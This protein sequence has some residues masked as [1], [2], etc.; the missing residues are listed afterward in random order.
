MAV[1]LPADGDLNWGPVLRAAILELDTQSTSLNAD[2]SAAQADA[3]AAVADAATA[4]ADAATAIS[5]A[6]AAA[7]DA[8]TASAAAGTAG[9]AAAS[10]GATATAAGAAAAAAASAA[11][12]ANSAAGTAQ[13]TADGKNK[14][15]IQSGTPTA[16]AAGDTWIDTGNANTIK[17][18]NGSTWS[19]RQLGSAAISDVAATIITGQIIAGQI[20]SG[21]ITTA[22]LSAG[23]VTANEIAANTVTAAKIAAATITAAEIAAATITG[24]KLV[25]GT[26]TA[27]EIAAN[28]ITAAKILAGTITANE[29]AAN[30]ITAAKIL[31]GTITATEIAAGTITAAKIA[32]GTITAA[33][34]NATALTAQNF[35]SAA[36]GSN[37][38]IIGPS[39]TFSGYPRVTFDRTGNG[40]EATDPYIGIDNSTGYL[41]LSGGTSGSNSGAT[42]VDM[43]N[44]GTVNQVS[45]GVV[46]NAGTLTGA[47][48][49]TAGTVTVSGNFSAPTAGK[50]ITLQGCYD[51]TTAAAATVFVDSA[52]VMKRSTA[53]SARYKEDI[54]TLGINADLDPEKLYS[55]PIRQFRYRADYLPDSDQFAGR[56]V[57]GFIAEEVNAV[58]PIAAERDDATGEIENWNARHMIPA[59][60]AL[61]QSQNKRI[62][63]LEKALEDME[64]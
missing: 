60:L 32:A 34:L 14:I 28:T 20:A 19:T 33:E 39:A 45:I 63:A 27:N 52:G 2:V 44:P 59:M 25:A 42:Y 53:S 38:I 48:D 15:F 24:G 58:Y 43:G 12:A 21:A 13:V 31:A 35:Y 36:G 10:A 5:D 55:L 18:W 16:S 37:R 17:T 62:T 8:A 49:I 57:P 7:A 1:T 30:T 29:I 56:E 50:T 4:V 9:T 46:N 11:S 22:K 51:T 23:A 26:I 54:A 40:A 64:I 3:A 47:V 41:R 61:I 6:A